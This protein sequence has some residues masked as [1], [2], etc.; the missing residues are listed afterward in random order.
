MCPNIKH[1][2][3]KKLRT[4]VVTESLQTLKLIQTTAV[5]QLLHYLILYRKNKLKTSM[6]SS[7]PHEANSF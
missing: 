1:L 6:Y 4:P 7:S 3:L 2:N 5:C